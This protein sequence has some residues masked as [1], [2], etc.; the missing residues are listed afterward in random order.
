VVLVINSR[1]DDRHLISNALRL[2]E[3]DF[4][5]LQANLRKRNLGLIIGKLYLADANGEFPELIFNPI[6]FI[7]T[8]GMEG[9]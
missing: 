8:M 6:E 7:Q 1:L 2:I 5:R 4:M 3:K 9:M